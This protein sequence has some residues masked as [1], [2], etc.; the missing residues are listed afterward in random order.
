V[1]E[2]E[3]KR[4][5]T[6]NIPLLPEN[7]LKLLKGLDLRAEFENLKPEH[8]AQL[9]AR[10]AEATLKDAANTFVNT[11]KLGVDMAVHELHRLGATANQIAKALLDINQNPDA[12]LKA[13]GL[14][15]ILG[16]I[17]KAL[18]SYYA[19][20]DDHNV[21]EMLKD[22]A[23]DLKLALKKLDDIAANVKTLE[24]AIA[25]L[26]EK[27]RKM[28]HSEEIKSL[29]SEIKGA[30]RHYKGL[31]SQHQGP[32]NKE[33]IGEVLD[34]YHSVY[35][36]R[37][38]LENDSLDDDVEFAPLAAAVS[39]LA[40]LLEL[41]LLF[42]LGKQY[43]DI[44][45]AATKEFQEWFDHILGSMPN[46]VA[47][48]IKE[49]SAKLAESDKDVAS[50]VLQLAVANPNTRQAVYC[51]EHQIGSTV[52]APIW[53][54]ASIGESYAEWDG[55]AGLTWIRFYGITT[56]NQWNDQGVVV[57]MVGQTI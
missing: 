14:T 25:A 46:S 56:L 20:Y 42:R 12:I 41:G 52:Q 26:P 35:K 22:I 1:I 29:N 31:L 49:K 6:V 47:S 39:P 50:G 45:A 11:L 23:Y 37:E 27:E 53:R 19:S 30:L 5:P 28:F 54:G 32:D 34:L 7:T 4:Y 17:A 18:L 2:Q 51:L 15:C 43:D 38:K 44:R 8:R 55:G 10:F 9:A 36:A 13:L 33:F 16:D 48:Y 57:W 24:D 21:R 40:M 3:L